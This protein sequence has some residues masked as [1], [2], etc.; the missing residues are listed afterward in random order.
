MDVW[1][2]AEMEYAYSVGFDEGYQAAND[3]IDAPSHARSETPTTANG[4][5]AGQSVG[6]CR[7]C[8]YFAFRFADDDCRYGSCHR[9]PETLDKLGS[10]WCG[11]YAE[12]CR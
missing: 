1:E 8:R 7:Q 2:T 10:E 6:L 9:F 5:T 12:V 4:E 11:E 3:E